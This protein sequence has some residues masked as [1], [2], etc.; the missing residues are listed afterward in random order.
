MKIQIRNLLFVCAAA[1]A[2]VGCTTAHNTTALD[3][4]KIQAGHGVNWLGMTLVNPTEDLMKKYGVPPDYPGP[5]MVQVQDHSFFPNGY[6]PTVGCA[7]WIVEK[8]AKGFLFNKEKS[9][10]YYPKT[11]RELAEALL[12]CTATP[13]EYQKKFNQT[14]QAAREYAE[15][16]KDNPAE[17][18]RILKIADWKMPE[19]DIGKYICRVVYNYPGTNG[20]M[21]TCV[22]MTKADLDQIREFIKK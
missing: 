1:L 22:R 11:I 15:T 6:A 9:P 8:P 12:S 18:E 13:E 3:N 17:R 21:T 14:A 5:I 16:L 10:S 19:D 4:K 2:F 7:F 20:T